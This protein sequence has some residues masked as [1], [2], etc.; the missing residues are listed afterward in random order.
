LNLLLNTEDLRVQYL[1]PIEF[2]FDQ[3]PG[4]FRLGSTWVHWETW[5]GEFFRSLKGGLDP[6]GE[7][8]GEIHF[9]GR[10]N[11][12]PLRAADLLVF[13]VARMR[14]NSWQHPELPLRKSLENLK[15]KMNLLVSFPDEKQ[16]LD[17]GRIIEIAAE[18]NAKGTSEEEIRCRIKT[19]IG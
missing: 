5:A 2:L 19:E 7:V 3:K 13:E 17:F 12:A 9:G 14:R 10:K 16:I 1:K 6:Q 4:R 8:L 15:K 11:Y 18:E